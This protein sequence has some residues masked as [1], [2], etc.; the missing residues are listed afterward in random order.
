MERDR[1]PMRDRD[2]QSS[3]AWSNA[4]Q[5]HVQADSGGEKEEDDNRIADARGKDKETIDKQEVLD[6]L[7]EVLDKHLKWTKKTAVAEV[8]IAFKITLTNKF[9]SVKVLKIE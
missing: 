5:R 8:T 2:R 6:D 3:A 4:C 9:K 7:M 1:R